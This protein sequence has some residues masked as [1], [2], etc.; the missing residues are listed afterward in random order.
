M[1]GSHAVELTPYDAIPDVVDSVPVPR[2]R[3]LV[4]GTVLAS[5]AVSMLMAGL[6]G[7]YLETRADVIA[8]GERW[9][10]PGVVIPLTQPNMMVFTLVLSMMSVIWAVSSIRRD[11]RANTHI[12]LGLCLLFGFAYIAQTAYL[13]EIMGLAIRGDELGRPPLLFALIFSH[14][15]LVV[16][17][18]LYAA[19]MG[20]R[21]L[22]GQY[23]SKDVEGLY[24]VAIFWSA[25]V[26]LY[27]VVWY[28]VY[29]T[30]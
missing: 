17:A 4:I 16:A 5:V 24:G 29:I 6:L 25:V 19:A 9:L 14:V 8:D 20:L 23:S 12:A 11:D 7:I 10:P 15:V 2:P 13:F 21:T 26:M 22:G 27:L 30:K 1:S 28:A 3:L 18:M